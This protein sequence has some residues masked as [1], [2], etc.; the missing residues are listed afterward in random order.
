MK[1]ADLAGASLEIMRVHEV[2]GVHDAYYSWSPYNSEVD[3]MLM[4][5]ERAYLEA[6]VCRLQKN[7]AVPVTSFLADSLIQE[8]ILARPDQVGRS[9]PA[10]RLTGEWPR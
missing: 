2:Y 1:I 3:A 9:D 4:E 10:R 8:G 6:V 5:R 7:T